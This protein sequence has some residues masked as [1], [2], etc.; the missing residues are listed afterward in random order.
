MRQEQVPHLVGR[1]DGDCRV[2]FG[3]T[4][5]PGRRKSAVGGNPEHIHSQRVVRILTPFGYRGLASRAAS[6]PSAHI[7]GEVPLV[8]CVSGAG[9]S[10]GQYGGESSSVWLVVRRLGRSW[11][12]R[13]NQDASPSSVYCGPQRWRSRC[14]AL[15]SSAL[16]GAWQDGQVIGCSSVATSAEHDS[17]NR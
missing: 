17:D 16:E 1:K 15:L 14:S 8:R 9:A 4:W 11:R 10:R 12:K 3:R 6:V 2:R 5:A 13:S 7:S